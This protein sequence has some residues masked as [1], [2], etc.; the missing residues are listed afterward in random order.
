MSS[1]TFIIAWFALGLLSAPLTH[2]FLVAYSW[3][4]FPALQCPERLPMLHR[5]HLSQSVAS[6]ICPAVL[7]AFACSGVCKHG[8]MFKLPKP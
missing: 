5:R 6:I 2:G 4:E 3:N 8:I 1:K 7:I